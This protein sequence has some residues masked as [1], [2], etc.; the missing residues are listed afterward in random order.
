M[1]T[2]SDPN[3]QPSMAPY[4]KINAGPE[5][6]TATWMP[7]RGVP[8]QRAGMPELSRPFH[9]C[10]WARLQAFFVEVSLS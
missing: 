7:R 2:V 1:P 8:M 9:S 6:L 4:F 5:Q 3:V 10:E